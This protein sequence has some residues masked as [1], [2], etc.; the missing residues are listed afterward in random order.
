M[1]KPN[2]TEQQAKTPASD[3]QGEDAGTA[4]SGNDE[5]AG[6]SQSTPSEK[7]MK[8]TSKTDTERSSQR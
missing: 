7:A 5:A 6:Q 8:Q 4:D 2:P 3:L 1:Q